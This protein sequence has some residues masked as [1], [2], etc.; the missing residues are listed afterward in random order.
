[1]TRNWVATILLVLSSAAFAADPSTTKGKPKTPPSKVTAEQARAV[2]TTKATF[3]SAVGSCARPT[4]CDP[5]S[6]TRDPD[7]VVLLETAEQSFMVACL[8]C[9][10]EAA[11]EEERVRIRDGRGRFGFNACMQGDPP[12]PA[13]TTGTKKP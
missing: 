1:M 4:A 3:M 8:Q 10:T 2:R 11:C 9:A 7:L 12:P 5:K 6:P 13:A